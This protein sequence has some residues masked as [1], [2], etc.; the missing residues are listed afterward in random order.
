MTLIEE[1][2][3]VFKRISITVTKDI[4]F[5]FRVVFNANV[6]LNEI[7]NKHENCHGHEKYIGYIAY[8]SETLEPAAYYSVYPG[9]LKYLNKIILVAQSGDTMTNPKYQKKGLFVKLANLTFDLCNNIG[10]EII[11]GIPNNNSSHGFLKYLDFI[12]QSRFKY[13][14]LLENK[15]EFYRITSKFDFTRKLHFKFLKFTFSIFFK[16]GLQI[17]NSNYKEK[18]LAFMIHDDVFFKA[19]EKESNLFISRKESHIWIKIHD[20][21]ISIAD[22][23][24]KNEKDLIHIIGIIKLIIFI[25]GYRFLDFEALPNSYLIKKLIPYANNITESNTLIIR[26]SSKIVPSNKISF[27]ICDRDSF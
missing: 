4:Q 12:E 11:T 1:K 9:H 26:N 7:K 22:I 13:L 14:S 25:T 10:I 8:D 27:L 3:F 2:K 15:F 21:H 17:E 24:F 6:S 20:N 16:R 23:L 5:L 18:N 19:K